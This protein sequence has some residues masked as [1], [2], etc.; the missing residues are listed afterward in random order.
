MEAGE[1]FIFFKIYIFVLFYVLQWTF[2]YNVSVIYCHN[3][4]T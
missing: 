1:R 3:N 2:I 4:T